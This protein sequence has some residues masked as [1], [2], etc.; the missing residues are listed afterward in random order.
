MNWYIGTSGWSYKEWKN[1]F[2]P[3]DVN[4]RIKRLEY[5]AGIFDCTEVNSTF[6]QNPGK[7]TLQSWVEAT[8][9]TFQFIIKLNRYFSHLKRLKSDEAVS[10]KYE[11]FKHLPKV[12]GNRMGPILV[13][14]PGS[15]KK[16]SERLEEWLNFMPG[17]KFAF[18]FRNSTW[19]D[20]EIYQILRKYKAALVYS[21]SRDFTTELKCTAGF[22]YIRFHGPDKPYHSQYSDDQLKNEMEK[23]RLFLHDCK[24]IYV[25]FNNTY[26]AYA[27]E[28]ARRWKELA[29]P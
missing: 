26:K 10:A 24:D 4:D 25:F 8:P 15:M 18:E 19:F 17:F 7:E 5:Y 22:M 16:N 23:I 28:N 13:Q 9:D 3:E 1:H 20:E 27:A 2:Y 12:L 11:E 6:Y 21:Q 14:L 29:Q